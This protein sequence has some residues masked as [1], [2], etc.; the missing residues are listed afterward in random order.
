MAVK[1]NNISLPTNKKFG[2]FFSII[3]LI[4]YFYL[5]N[6]LFLLPSLFFLF[7]SFFYSK[8]LQ[9]LNNLWFKLGILLGNIVSPFVL[10]FIFFTL[11]TPI[12]LIGKLFQRNLLKLYLDKKIKTYWINRVNDFTKD[13]FNNQF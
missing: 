10:A 6:I 5:T 7:F 11:I 4:L 3:F 8:V 2:I 9:P 13:D 12:S 1:N